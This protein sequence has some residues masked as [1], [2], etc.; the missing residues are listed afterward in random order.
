MPSH[1]NSNIEMFKGLGVSREIRRIVVNG[2]GYDWGLL[3]PSTSSVNGNVLHRNGDRPLIS[4][5]DLSM[6]PQSLAHANPF[7]TYRSAIGPRFSPA[8]SNSA[9]DPKSTLIEALSYI[10]PSPPA[11]LPPA[12]ITPFTHLSTLHVMRIVVDGKLLEV[13]SGL[14]R[15]RAVTLGFCSMTLDV[16][17]SDW[18]RWR[19][20]PNG[21]E[22]PGY[23]RPT[24]AH[25]AGAH[26]RPTSIE[27]DD[28]GVHLP[29][30]SQV[31]HLKLYNCTYTCSRRGGIQLKKKQFPVHLL[32]PLLGS[33]HLEETELVAPA[34]DTVGMDEEARDAETSS[35]ASEASEVNDV[36]V[37]EQ[38]DEDSGTLPRLKKITLSNLRCATLCYVLSLLQNQSGV[39]SGLTHFKLH[40]SEGHQGLPF[41]LFS[42]QLHAFLPASSTLSSQTT[43]VNYI[44]HPV[45]LLAAL[46][47]SKYTLHTLIL[48]NIPTRQATPTLFAHLKD[49]LPVLRGFSVFA[50]GGGGV[51]PTTGNNT[52]TGGW[53]A[54][55]GHGATGIEA[56][57]LQT[58]CV[59]TTPW[60]SPPSSYAL[61][62]AAWK[63]LEWFAWNA[64]VEYWEATPA[65]LFGEEEGAEKEVIGSGR[66][67]IRLRRVP[68]RN[69][70]RLKQASPSTSSR[71]AAPSVR[72]AAVPPQQGPP[73]PLYFFDAHTCTMPFA[74][75]LPSLR[76]FSVWDG[77]NAEMA[78]RVRRRREMV[79]IEG[80]DGREKG[81]LYEWDDLDDGE[82]R[83]PKDTNKFNRL[84]CFGGKPLEHSASPSDP[85]DA[86]YILIPR[87]FGGLS[88]LNSTVDADLDLQSHG[89]PRSCRGDGTFVVDGDSD[90]T[91]IDIANLAGEWNPPNGW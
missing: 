3:G 66:T 9:A 42:P 22:S 15:L 84:G 68:A 48:S 60:P 73:A 85:N 29:I 75:L 71:F 43:N 12:T 77:G 39:D 76:F 86:G 67:G 1:K 79:D 55:G 81:P 52:G 45:T 87:Y 56:R 19:A 62:M 65:G 34:A 88:V 74:A 41:G 33:L 35:G 49:A 25:S 28:F 27:S 59:R 21:Q 7:S 89:S 14:G 70:I 78:C 53:G 37:D 10:H 69:N 90:E 31:H 2:L 23:L 91:D 4:M 61:S 32:F 83:K 80:C 40:L 72:F 26:L 44:Q 58:Q 54:L 50:R 18:E 46:H 64:R 13:M 5:R 24:N 38:E 8:A 30:L 47:P 6:T 82:T 20:G 57:R 63:N 16:E 36:D 51:A 11:E 17:S